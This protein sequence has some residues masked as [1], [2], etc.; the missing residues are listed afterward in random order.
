M[1][2]MACMAETVTMGPIVEM[3]IWVAMI[4]V[5]YV[6]GK[7]DYHLFFLTFDSQRTTRSTTT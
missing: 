7:R 6:S 3:I 5:S 4:E 2:T 1:V